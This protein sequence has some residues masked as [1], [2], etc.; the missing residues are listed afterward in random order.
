MPGPR[1]ARQAPG[2]HLQQIT[3]ARPLEPDHLLARRLRDPGE[4]VAA[5]D[6]VHGRVRDT[7]PAG[8]QPR[9]VAAALTLG[10]DPPLNHG[11]RSSRRAVG[12]DERSNA[13]APDAISDAVADNRRCFHLRA[14]RDETESAAA[15]ALSDHL[16]SLEDERARSD[17]PVRA[18]P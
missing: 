6:R 17:P 14:V 7:D 16:R 18:C 8:D 3:R 4:A 13:H 12:R 9:P 15:A 1:E 5:Q 11:R 2:V 10:T